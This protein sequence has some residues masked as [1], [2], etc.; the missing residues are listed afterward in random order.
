MSKSV[1]PRERAKSHADIQH[2]NFYAEALKASEQF[3]KIHCFSGAVDI[4]IHRLPQEHD[5]DI[6]FGCK[7]PNLAQDVLAAPHPFIPAGKRNNAKGAL[8][9]AAF[10]DGHVCAPRAAAREGF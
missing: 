10:A 7:V 3:R 4:G 6:P 5:F 8:P 1:D 9:V 2:V